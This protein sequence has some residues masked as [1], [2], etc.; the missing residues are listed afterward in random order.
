MS[1]TP[2]TRGK[3]SILY[4]R[5]RASDAPEFRLPNWIEVNAL[6][7][8]LQTYW[9][10][11][12]MGAVHIANVI[13]PQEI[14]LSQSTAAIRAMQRWQIP[15]AIQSSLTS[16]LGWDQA[17]VDQF[18]AIVGILNCSCDGGSIGSYVIYGTV[19]ELGQPGW[20][21]C[22]KCQGLAF[23]DDQDQPGK[24]PAGR[25]HDHLSSGAYVARFDSDGS[26]ELGW[27]Y[28]SKCR[29]MVYRGATTGICVDGRAHDLG[30][31]GAYR[32]ILT[33]SPSGT[34][35]S[36][37]HRCTNCQVLVAGPGAWGACKAGGVHT[38]D[39]SDYSVG[40][41]QRPSLSW[42]GH[43]SGHALGLDHAFSDAPDGDPV[44]DDRPG[45]YGDKW[46][47]MSFGNALTF[48]STRVV[49]KGPG[50]AAPTLF[51]NGWMGEER[52]WPHV[53][54]GPAKHIIALRSTSTP[55][56]TGP[57]TAQ[58]SSTEQVAGVGFQASQPVEFQ[59]TFARIAFP[60]RGTAYSVEYR[61]PANWDQ[62]IRTEGVL[63]REHQALPDTGSLALFSQ[64]G[65]RLCARCGCLVYRGHRACA[66][67]GEHT[68][69]GAHLR[70]P[71]GSTPPSVP[72]QAGW[73]WCRRCQ[74]L[75]N[76]GAGPGV[77]TAGGSHNTET[78]GE[79][80][81]PQGE[82]NDPASTWRWCRRCKCLHDNAQA[83]A[84][85]CASGDTHDD[86]QSGI[87]RLAPDLNVGAS[88]HGWT[89]CSKCSVV[90]YNQQGICMAGAAHDTSQSADYFLTL[91]LEG[92]RG[93]PGWRW[94]SKCYGLAFLDAV[95]GPGLCPVGDRHDHSLSG[96]YTV[97][98][99]PTHDPNVIL[100]KW[101][102]EVEQPGWAYC[103]KC[104]QLAFKAGNSRCPGYGGVHD[105]SKSGAYILRSEIGGH[106]DKGRLQ[107]ARS[108]Q[109]GET[110]VNLAGDLQVKI[111]GFK[112][113]PSR[114]EI[115][116]TIG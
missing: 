78:S 52:V 23:W 74:A 29:S 110:Y 72:A 105:F 54:A 21:W 113:D 77:C 2:T 79:Y 18:K 1:I 87:Y 116:I 6:A 37:W 42:L 63:I 84:D 32:V 104:E 91:G 86:S 55:E 15:P 10:D 27:R 40:W 7:A 8:E 73:R 16:Q 106:A 57:L 46:D 53:A 34:A 39:A 36:G 25:T 101:V 14:V 103:S 64:N 99:V 31:S 47:V 102:K 83:A 12:S 88:Q 3:V 112:T 94:C 24:C 20:R 50:V 62:G 115:E 68:S 100:P 71:I 33:S 82:L 109:V 35:Q 90:F 5:V 76:E 30:A 66:T 97:E 111:L 92:A 51:K 26:G 38:L 56:V 59:G 95:R 65:W 28:C 19:Q 49:A 81:V 22:S 67:G 108:W 13:P 58:T 61:T 4:V 98:F 107:Q 85:R 43:E 96:H 9:H 114:A 80:W 11:I 75:V 60:K 93:Q 41:D 17:Q 48:P 89:A 44:S 45:A 69:S 70:V